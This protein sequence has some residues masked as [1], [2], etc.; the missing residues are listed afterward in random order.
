MHQPKKG[1][2]RKCKNVAPRLSLRQHVLLLPPGRL[3]R[4]LVLARHPL[5]VLVDLIEPAS[6]WKDI[7][8][9]ANLQQLRRWR[10]SSLS[11]ARRAADAPNNLSEPPCQPTATA[12]CTWLRLMRWCSSPSALWISTAAAEEPSAGKIVNGG[13]RQS[14]TSFLTPQK[15]VA[16]SIM[17]TCCLIPPALA[18]LP[19]GA[20]RLSLPH[21]HPPTTTQLLTQVY[22]VHGLPCCVHQRHG[23]VVWYVHAHEADGAHGAGVVFN[24]DLI[25]RRGVG[26]MGG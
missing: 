21:H 9:L 12:T 11:T 10:R 4:L 15:K 19:L 6:L 16:D 3:L 23:A 1:E 14:A 8:T 5:V 25:L 24:N 22:C 18:H 2:R 7:K 26:R 17:H 20:P 13:R